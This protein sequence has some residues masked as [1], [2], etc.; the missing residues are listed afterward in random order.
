M[1]FSA[2]LDFS[3]SSIGLLLV[4][5]LAP[6]AGTAFF[7]SVLV[8]LIFNKGML[9]VFKPI[10]PNFERISL[11]KGFE[12]I[13]GSRGW[14]ETAQALARFFIWAA[15]VALIIW[16]T[17]PRIKAID[18]CGLSCAVEVSRD[19]GLAIAIAGIVVLLVS[20]GID[21]LLQVFLFLRE[22]RM[23]DSEV[24][25]EMKEQFG[26]REIRQERKRQRKE[27][28][29][30]AEF[31]GIQKANMCFYWQDSAVAIRYHPQHTPLPRISAKTRTKL[32]S[33]KLREQVVGNG[34]PEM[35]HQAITETTLRSELGAGIDES[36]FN[37]FVQAL[38]LMF[39]VRER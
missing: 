31:V 35:E 9:F 16:L 1:G 25:R 30:G 13:Y 19:L 28:T 4:L 27:N 21:M 20:G 2:G 36:I 18:R 26:S 6:V 29:E 5:I 8:A 17:L 12:R 32:A 15:I 34:F 7:V 22:Q 14:A 11:S 3:I 24:K 37:T 10:V 38:Q 39:A 33:Q 23:S